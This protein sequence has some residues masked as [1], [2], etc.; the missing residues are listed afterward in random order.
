[1]MVRQAHH[2]KL[3]NI[4]NLSN[5]ELYS[6]CKEYGKNARKWTRRFGFLLPEIAKRKMYR[7]Y[8][9]AGIHEFAAKL[10]GMSHDLTSRILCLANRLEDKPLIWSEFKKYGWGKLEIVARIATV[11]SQD[12]WLDKLRKLPINVLREYVKKWIE[13]NKNLLE[14]TAPHM[15]SIM[16]S[17]EKYR[18]EAV[19][20]SNAAFVD[21]KNDKNQNFSYYKPETAGTLKLVNGFTEGNLQK[22]F[23]S[24]GNHLK[25]T[26]NADTE[27][28]IAEKL[29][30]ESQSAGKIDDHNIYKKLK[31]RVDRDTEFEFKKFKQALEKERKEALTMGETLKVLLERVKWPD[32]NKNILKRVTGEEK[33]FLRGKNLHDDTITMVPFGGLRAGSAHHDNT[34]PNDSVAKFSRENLQ[35][36]RV[37]RKDEAKHDNASD[38]VGRDDATRY[39]PPKIK[40]AAVA[41]NNGRCAFPR[42]N[43]PYVELHHPDRFSLKK[44]HGRLYPL[45]RMH[46]QFAH[47]GLIKNEGGD[48]KNWKINIKSCE[49]DDIAKRNVQR[50]ELTG[51][52]NAEIKVATKNVANLKLQEVFRQYEEMKKYMIDQNAREYWN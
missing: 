13:H 40:M 16:K 47:S 29:S 50:N 10:A 8:R 49:T 1:M 17:A 11:E 31:F 35:D 43:E 14:S 34:S 45:C 26:Q 30:S 21:L 2:D 33:G 46:H 7:K 36:D 41:A 37:W 42:C 12:F 44:S 3:V 15:Q 6:L 48:V 4:Q 18:S 22:N 28:V 39:I 52:T 38:T 25:M 32:S 19:F 24:A 27:S 51:K 23:E 20:V 9:C 5:K